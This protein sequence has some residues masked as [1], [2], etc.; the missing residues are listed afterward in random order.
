M[1]L[2]LLAIA[3]ALNSGLKVPSIANAVMGMRTKWLTY[4]TVIPDIFLI[5]FVV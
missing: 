3:G 2:T 5:A 1:P 4:Y